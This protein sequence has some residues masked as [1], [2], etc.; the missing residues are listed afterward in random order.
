[1]PRLVDEVIALTTPNP[2]RIL[3]YDIETAP[4]L[5]WVWQQW[6]TN[7][8]AIE[9]DWYLLCFAYKW[10]GQKQTHWRAITDDPSFTPDTTN[11]RAL[12]GELWELLDRADIVIAHN[13]DQFDQ[14]KA[15]ARFLYHGLDPPSPY[16]TVDTLREARRQFN[17]FSN[18][19]NE[20][21]RYYLGKEKEPHEGFRM[22]RGCMAGDP[23]AWR[24]MRRYN[25]RDV[26]ILEDVYLLLRPWIGHPG[27]RAHPNLGLWARGERVCTRC[28]SP[29]LIPSGT[30]RVTH[31][32]QAWRCLNCGGVSRSRLRTAETKPHEPKLI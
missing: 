1:M 32:Y 21:G 26:A 30:H 27:K 6:K 11:D 25:R 22:W 10:L 29:D 23:K 4:A 24:T 5:G 15:N 20:L 14:R 16:Q 12:V 8:V 28:G 9:R 3:L 31:Q 13:G 2:P 18:S 7:V 19:L 17:N